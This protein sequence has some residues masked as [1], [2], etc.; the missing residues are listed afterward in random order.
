MIYLH[1][2][3]LWNN[4]S[5]RAWYNMRVRKRVLFMLTNDDTFYYEIHRAWFV[6]FWFCNISSGLIDGNFKIL[7]PADGVIYMNIFA[8]TEHSPPSRLL[9][10]RCVLG[11][12]KVYCRDMR[13]VF[14][15]YHHFVW[16]FVKS[17]R[18]CLNWSYKYSDYHQ[19]FSINVQ[20]LLEMDQL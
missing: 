16:W 11:L 6:L 8:S 14:Q 15:V 9:C 4:L 5:V 18:S 3:N 20:M 10:W 2:N 7:N 13:A 12:H 17:F 19:V 1:I